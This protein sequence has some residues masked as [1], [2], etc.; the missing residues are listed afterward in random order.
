[1]RATAVRSL[2]LLVL[3]AGAA[4]GEEAT[5][6]APAPGTV[7]TETNT[8]ETGASESALE[9][10]LIARPAT[11]SRRFNMDVYAT[12]V[13]GLALQEADDFRGWTVGLDFTLPL[14]RAMQLRALLPVRTEGEAVLR[15]SD[16]DIDIEGWSG[17]FD[18]G[19]LFFEHQLVGRDGGAN[20][21]A[22]YLGMGWRTG[23]L[24]TD[25]PDKY[26]HQGRSIH[27]GGRYE[28]RFVAGS[29]VLVDA[30]YRSYEI[31]D[32]LNPANLNDD[33]FN[34]FRLTGAW[35]GAKRG[36]LRPAVELTAQAVEDWLPVSVVPEL[37]LLTGS[38]MT[39]KFGIPVGLTA[40]APDWGA[41][42]RATLAF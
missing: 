23:V 4:R 5:V 13:E 33:R 34:L 32:D 24:E 3:C 14:T 12:Y 28:R 40:D 8:S 11:T 38:T 42:M 41:E 10:P 20:R 21:F 26:N 1:M 6:E 22:Y 9:R 31:S 30:E 7:A 35:M 27:L 37:F 19:T 18:F 36:V 16:E 15:A 29:T 2:L 39:V 25:T 17:L